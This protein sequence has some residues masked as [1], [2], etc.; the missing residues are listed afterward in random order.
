M[1]TP[2]FITLNDVYALPGTPQDLREWVLRERWFPEV[3]NLA[4]DITTEVLETL[5]A[6]GRLRVVELAAPYIDGNRVAELRT[7]WFDGAPFAVVQDAGRGGDDHRR[8]W[9]TDAK[10]YAAAL[11]YLLQHLVLNARTEDLVNPEAPF[12]PEEVLNFYGH[13]FA[14]QLG[15]APEPRNDQYQFLGESTR[16]LGGPDNG[17]ML[18]LFA[19]DAAPAEF[20]RRGGTVMRFEREPNEAEIAINPRLA[21]GPDDGNQRCLWYRVCERPA[22]APVVS[23]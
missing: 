21:T 16:F 3:P 13:D 14:T 18:V 11:Q 2:R 23:I 12:Y 20:V 5:Q 19:G 15:F 1:T 7:L 8:R 10:A 6:E 17:L 22:D 4:Y 9:V